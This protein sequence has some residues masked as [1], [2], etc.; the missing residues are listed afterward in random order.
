MTQE[1]VDKLTIA[2]HILEIP[3]LEIKKMSDKEIATKLEEAKATLTD[4]ELT[5][6]I[7]NYMNF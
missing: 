4:E 2:S 3:W 6:R 7:N 5:K 1:R